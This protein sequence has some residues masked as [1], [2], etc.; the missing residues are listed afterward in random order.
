VW[1]TYIAPD[2]EKEDIEK[3]DKDYFSEEVQ[4][5]LIK[6]ATPYRED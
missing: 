3:A 4:K 1:V 2:E 5:I 6:H